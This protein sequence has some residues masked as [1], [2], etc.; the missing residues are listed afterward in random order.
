MVSKQP[1][2]VWW[3][4]IEKNI[5]NSCKRNYVNITRRSVFD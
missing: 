5:R 3:K 4:S 2:I 1:L